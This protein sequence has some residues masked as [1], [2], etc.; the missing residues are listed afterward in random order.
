MHAAQVL[1]EKIL[2]IEVVVV[3][4]LIV[5]GISGWWADIASP[6]AELDVLGVDVPLPFVL[7]GEG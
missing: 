7:G 1:C 4:G 2:A 6:E 3:D 5:I